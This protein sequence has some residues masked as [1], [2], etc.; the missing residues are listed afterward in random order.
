M[1]EVVLKYFTLF[2][3]MLVTIGCSSGNMYETKGVSM[4]KLHNKFGTTQTETQ[5]KEVKK[6]QVYYFVCS[7]Y[8]KKFHGRQTSN[9]EIFDMYKLTCA[10]K[11]LPFGTRLKVINEDNGKSVLVRVND[12]GPFI[13]GRDLDLSYAAAQE[14][15]LIAHGVKKMRVEVLGTN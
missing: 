14:I 9:G 5:L 6:G 12:R 10:H 15:G 8:G 13:E 7:Y 1:P 4:K 3:L 11:S 2:L